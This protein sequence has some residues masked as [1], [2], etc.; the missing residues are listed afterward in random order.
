[1]EE[2]QLFIYGLALGITGGLFLGLYLGR[3][4]ERNKEKNMR[5]WETTREKGMGHFILIYG[6]LIWGGLTGIT[7]FI[8][9][10][11][12]DPS[13][14]WLMHL[15]FNMTLFPL[16]GLLWGW[17]VWRSAEKTYTAWKRET[18]ISK[19]SLIL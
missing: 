9:L 10:E 8:I 2:V 19:E 1:M 11:L 15:T 13:S 5:K 4:G 3:K 6:V 17:L 16:G 7:T 14:L 18:S 12:F